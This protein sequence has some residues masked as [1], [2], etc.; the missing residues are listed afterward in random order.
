[1]KNEPRYWNRVLLGSTRW[2]A[3]QVVASTK[4]RKFYG[5]RGDLEE[6]TTQ[7]DQTA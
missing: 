3:F 1:M 7:V 6:V 5:L 4:P 2:E